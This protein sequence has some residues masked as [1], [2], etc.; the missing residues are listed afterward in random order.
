MRDLATKYEWF[1]TAYD[2]SW[3]VAV[4]EGRAADDVVRVYGGDPEQPAGTWT[5]R[6]A[7]VP[8]TE[9]GHY[10][11]VQTLTHDRYV[12]AIENNGWSGSIPEIARR[13]SQGK[14]RY[15]SVYWNVNG[16]SNIT[17][18]ENGRVIAYFDPLYVEEGEGPQDGEIYPEWIKGLTIDAGHVRST[19]LALV[20][21]QTGLAFDRSWLDTALPTYRIPDPDVMLRNVDGAREP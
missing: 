13:A 20:E 1:D 17:Q 11:H 2:L 15:L 5:Y 14:A 4:I 8:E 6:Q 10:F 19:A 12:V 3:T 21:Q 7:T 16:M 9:F 18:A